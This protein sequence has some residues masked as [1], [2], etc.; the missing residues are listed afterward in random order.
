MYIK[1]PKKFFL[2]DG[3]GAL[4]SSILL[5]FVL[6]PLENHLGFPASTLYFLACFPVLFLGFDAYSYLKMDNKTGHR[7]KT[8]AALNLFYCF[9]SMGFA[10]YHYH[11]L[12]NWAWGYILLE[13][14]AILVLVRMEWRLA[15]RLTETAV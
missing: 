7:L 12:S 2:L 1:N 3:M 5:A 8:I 15:E 9:L 6:P 10:F 4:L 11:T 14:S 13:I